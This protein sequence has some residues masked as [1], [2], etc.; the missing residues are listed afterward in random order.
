M[1]FVAWMIV[2]LALFVAGLV[3]VYWTG[4]RIER[5][6]P[7]LAVVYLVTFGAAVPIA[8][9]VATQHIVRIEQAG[10]DEL[11]PSLDRLNGASPAEFRT[12]CI[13][14]Q[15]NSEWLG[16]RRQAHGTSF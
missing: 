12:R 11:D 7:S 15:D 9:W 16:R 14:T 1:T 3:L 8:S 5:S 13:A 6:S 4:V 10:C 2:W